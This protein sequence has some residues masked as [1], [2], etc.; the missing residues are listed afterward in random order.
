MNKSKV[1]KLKRLALKK[2]LVDRYKGM[3]DNELAQHIKKKDSFT[4]GLSP[5]QIA[6]I[7]YLT[8]RS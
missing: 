3:T 4:D 1:R 2:N 7:K 6:H 5:Q 8:N